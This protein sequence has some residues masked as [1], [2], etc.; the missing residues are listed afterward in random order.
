[1][2]RVAAFAAL[3]LVACS[4]SSTPAPGAGTTMSTSAAGGAG[5]TTTETGPT[6]THTTSPGTGGAGGATAT[7]AGGATSAGGASAGGASAG[8]AGGAASCVGEPGTFYAQKD[9][10]YDI[11]VLD[12]VPMC[13]Y[14]GK[15]VLVVNTAALCGYTPQYGPLE[16]L[17]ETYG[18]QGFEV[19]GFLSND[20]GE[21]A[22]DGSQIAGCTSKYDVKFTQY[23]IDHVTDQDS[24]GK[25]ATPRPVYS[26]LGA[27][28]AQSPAGTKYP[29]WNFHKYLL[30]RTGE[31]VAHW[32]SPTDPLDPSIKAAV[33]AE[34]AK[35]AP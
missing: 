30:S 32:A 28:A 35:P 8:G 12:P 14:R 5:A 25:S 18:P 24:G 31:L 11:D 6:T 15:V 20:F 16:Q 7:G 21:P 1:M 33:E 13:I 22:G 4:S 2:I 34:L 19:V 27:Q 10:S 26:W 3:A 9:I 17:H 29:T 23:G